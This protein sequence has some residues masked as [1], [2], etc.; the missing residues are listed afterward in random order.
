[1][2]NTDI[3]WYSSEDLNAPS[4]PADWNVLT[5]VLDACLINGYSSQSF[6]RVNISDGVAIATF[7][8]NHSFKQFQV[9]EISGS[10]EDILNTEFKILGISP[11]T[12]EF[13]VDLPDGDYAGVMSARLAPLGWNKPFSDTGRAVY[14]A[15][16]ADKNPYYLRVDCTKD[17]SYPDS[18]AKFAKVG[19]LKS[20]AGIDDITG[21]Q[22]PFNE[23]SPLQNWKSSGNYHGYAKWK[24]ATIGNEVLY[25]TEG[26]RVPAGIRSWTLIGND[27][28]FYL[29]INSSLN[30]LDE[31]VYGFGSVQTNGTARP[32]LLSTLSYDQTGNYYTNSSALTNSAL[33]WVSCIYD[34]SNNIKSS[35]GFKLIT[36]FGVLSSGSAGNSIKSDPIQGY[37]LTPFYL[38]DP[39]NFIM[40]ELPMIRCCINNTAEIS[41]KSYY[42]DSGDIYYVSRYSARHETSLAQGMLFFKISGDD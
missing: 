37:Y 3:K 28:S 8:A 39:A 25:G 11:A 34:Y 6:S 33:K 42:A 4:L 13:V 19:I 21:I 2:A 27:T 36:G 41:N 1:M 10:S 35:E 15:K 32:F 31:S 40:G 22:A 5:N 23:S 38:L 12:I 17:A 20:C 14:R 9:V 26:E 30:R 16:N 24:Y 29:V 18:Y 7:N